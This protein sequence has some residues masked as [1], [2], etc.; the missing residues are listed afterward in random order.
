MDGALPLEPEDVAEALAPEADLGAGGFFDEPLLAELEELSRVVAARAPGAGRA[1]ALADL[2]AEFLAG[3]TPDEAALDETAFAALGGAALTERTNRLILLV[4]RSPL[5]DNAADVENFAVFFRALVPTLSDLG[6]DAVRR[7]FFRLVPSLLQLAY[8]EAAER[9]DTRRQGRA[10]LRELERVLLEIANVRLLPLESE[11]VLRSIDQMVAFMSAA[12]YALASELVSTQ[13]LSLIARNKLTRALYRL[14]E[15][16]VSLQRYLKSK[17]GYLTPQMRLPKDAGALAD[18]G[19]LRIFDEPFLD[20]VTRRLVQVQVPG[21]P[22]LRDVVL[23]LVE[24]ESGR[25]H[26]L[27]L[28]RLGS[29]EL[30]LPDGLYVLGLSYE[31]QG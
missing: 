28:D 12:E 6:S 1:A 29:A 4:R 23:H 13:L 18:Y 20:G 5:R 24:A 11:L 14:M 16:E 8:D 10:A 7:A 15:V 26:A 9:S 2:L 25:D 27:R 17:L 31:P 3:S 30:R 21:I 22:S 19:P